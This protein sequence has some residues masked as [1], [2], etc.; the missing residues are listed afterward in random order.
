MAVL[1]EWPFLTDVLWP[2]CADNRWP[3]YPDANNAYIIVGEYW[4]PEEKIMKITV[5]D[6]TNNVNIAIGFN[7][8]IQRTVTSDS[9]QATAEAMREYGKFWLYHLKAE[10]AVEYCTILAFPN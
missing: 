6:K 2:N 8:E 5:D 9:V 3:V 4:W 1:F 7:D 10:Q